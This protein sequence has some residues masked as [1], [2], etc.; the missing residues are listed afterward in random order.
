MMREHKD[1]TPAAPD[2]RLR[3]TLTLLSAG[4]SSEDDQPTASDGVIVQCLGPLRIWIDGRDCGFLANRRARSVLMYLLLHRG[5]PTPKELLMYLLWP[6]AAPEAA[7]NNLN[8]AVHRLRRFLAGDGPV[9][10]VVFRRGGYELDPAIPVWLDLDRFLERVAAA[11]ACARVGDRVGELRELEAAEVLYGGALFEDDPYEEWTFDR[12]RMVLDRYVDVL[13]GLARRHLD[14][15]DL[16]GAAAAAQKILDLQPAHES[17]H[18]MLMST[19]VEL[20]QHHLAARQFEDCK[21]ALRAE[22]DLAPG[23]ETVA[24]YGEIRAGR[25]GQMQTTKGSLRANE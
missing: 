7:R 8:V 10:H 16:H 5:R 2:E 9:R 20:G 25:G 3:R 13:D 21:G 12:R 15:D 23:P 17:A 6:T 22:L 24:L 11:R 1:P 18:R 19:Y 4:D 14:N